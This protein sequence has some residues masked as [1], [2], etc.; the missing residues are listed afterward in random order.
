MT[1]YTYQLS[2]IKVAER[3]ATLVLTADWLQGRSAYGGWQAALAVLAMRAV[4][5]NDI[6]LRSLQ[7][8]FIAPVPPGAVSATAEVL[9]RGKSVAQLEAR[10]LVDGKVAF[11]AVGIFGVSRNSLIEELTTAPPASGSPETGVNWPDAEGQRPAFSRNF[12]YR[13]SPGKE[14]YAGNEHS[15]GQIYVRF[16]DDAVRSE[17]H[18]ICMADAIPPSGLSRLTSPSPL[19]TINWTLELINPIRDEERQHWLRFDNSLTAAFD[20]YSWENTSIWSEKGSLL[21][22]SRQCVAVFS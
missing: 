10:I 13:W 4:V 12:E 1:N 17:A 7:S 15:E 16:S 3:C 18:L 19:S 22:L 8:N 11:A 21:A 14:P 9:R 20:G 5:G 2:E 6:A